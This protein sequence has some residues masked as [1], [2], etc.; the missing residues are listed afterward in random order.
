MKRIIII[1]SI[2]LTLSVVGVLYGEHLQTD[3]R[4]A[5][6]LEEA[7]AAQFPEQMFDVVLDPMVG[8]PIY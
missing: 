7:Y 6:T 1:L 8:Y 3:Q 4:E 2:V 5:A